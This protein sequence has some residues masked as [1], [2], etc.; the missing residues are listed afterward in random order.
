MRYT[1]HSFR[2]YETIDGVIKVLGRHNYSPAEMQTARQAFDELNGLIVP[3]PG[4]QYK[5]PLLDTV[6]DFGNLVKAETQQ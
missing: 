4:M 6:D 5:I 2:P 1:I 3:K